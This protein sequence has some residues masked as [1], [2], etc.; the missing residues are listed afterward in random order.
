MISK[1]NYF[2]EMNTLYFK[3]ILCSLLILIL[4]SCDT[5]KSL[6]KKGDKF[7]EKNLYQDASI[8]Y[9]KALDKKGDFIAAKEGLRSS[10]QKQVNAYLM[11]FS[12]L[13]T[14]AIKE[15]LSII[16]E[17]LMTQKKK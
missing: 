6:T 2:C 1:K 13:K 7:A 5:P 15:L 17:M 8:Q 16:T 9:M 4:A 14:L 3:L 12:S 11:I 10:G